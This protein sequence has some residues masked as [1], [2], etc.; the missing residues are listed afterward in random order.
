MRPGEVTM[1]KSERFSEGKG[2][3]G[4]KVARIGAIKVSIGGVTWRMEG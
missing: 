2:D 3:D 4:A 1:H